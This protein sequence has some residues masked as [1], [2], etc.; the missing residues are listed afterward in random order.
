MKKLYLLI[1]LIFIVFPF[2]SQIVINE[3]MADNKLCI[4][5]TDGDYSDWIELYN[6]HNEIINLNNYFLSDDTN[7]LTKWAFPN[8][9]IEPDST[10]LIFASG[11]NIVSNYE[12]HTNFK[13]SSEGEFICLSD[14]SGGLIDIINPVILDDD[15][16]YGRLPD[17]ASNLVHLDIF[18]PNNSNNN[19]SQLVFSESAGFY[20]QSFQLSIKS[21]LN[22]A[23]YYSLDGSVPNMNSYLL[24]DSILIY[25][26]SD[27]DNYF[28]TIPT[29]YHDH[30]EWSSPS[31]KIDKANIIRCVS[32]NNGVPSSKIYTQ[33]YFVDTEIMDKYDVPVISLVTDEQNLFDHD[34]GIYVPGVFFNEKEPAWSGNFHQKGSLWERPVHIEYF[35]TNGYSVLS[36]DAGVRIHGGYSRSFP[37]K[38]LRMYARSEYSKSHF[39]YPLLPRTDNTAYKR[40]L[41][42]GSMGSLEHPIIKDEVAHYI[43]SDLNFETQDFQPVIVFLNGEYWGIHTIR[44]YIDGNFIEYHHAIDSDSINLIT[45]WHFAHSLVPEIF[46]FIDKENLN[47]FDTYEYIK[48]IIDIPNYIDYQITEMFF[49]NYDWPENNLKC[50]KSNLDSSKWRF[51]FYDLDY[52]LIDDPAYNMFQHCT[53]TDES[54]IWPNTTE[55]TLL[56][57]RLM[58]I[59]E[60]QDDFINRVNE[61][62][63]DVF[64]TSQTTNKV[65]NV[66]EMY[67]SKILS[68]MNRWGW[69]YSYDDWIRG[70]N[71]LNHF[72]EV[73]PCE[74]AYNLVDFLDS[75]NLSYDWANTFCDNDSYESQNDILVYPNPNNGVF[76]IKNQTGKNVDGRLFI[77]NINGLIVYDDFSFHLESSEKDFFD[78]SHLSN[79]FYIVCFTDSDTQTLTKLIVSGN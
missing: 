34:S 11:K 15:E 39:N 19:T 77:T 41:L 68:H 52:A 63:L 62:L 8:I 10:L 45:G 66:A 12:I 22:H 55:S 67:D 5:D 3:I 17:G 43:A 73:R 50:W 40:F 51:V 57:R 30:V 61:I 72:L 74:F 2:H 58:D 29:T 59:S 18:S 79:G 31:D 69:P 13:I 24:S 32:Y 20:T 44:D 35:N 36:Q 75:N 47:D 16:S 60:F 28:A 48:N 6:S 33:T 38:T 9:N 53:N 71:A 78:F 76:S 27:D 70:I 25:N 14:I 64:S 23:I 54:V 1:G 21:L 7:N 26:R 4:M 37:Q 56:F 46:A 65:I 49:A 42:R